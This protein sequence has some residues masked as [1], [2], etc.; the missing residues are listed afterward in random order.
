MGVNKNKDRASLKGLKRLCQDEKLERAA[1]ALAEMSVACAL[2]GFL[3]PDAQNCAGM[4]M[5]LGSSNRRRKTESCSIQDSL[6]EDACDCEIM[7]S[8]DS[9][10][11]ATEVPKCPSGH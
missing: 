9:V 8:R 5:K 1:D 7:G 3:F 10:Q 2:T 4:N 11:D 6:Q